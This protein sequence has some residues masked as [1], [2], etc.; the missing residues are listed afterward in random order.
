MV[1]SIAIIGMRLIAL[2]W[3]MSGLTITYFFGENWNDNSIPF[4]LSYVG[5]IIFGIILWVTA[6]YLQRY[7]IVEP[8]EGISSSNLELEE[9]VAAGSFLM[10]LYLFVTNIGNMSQSYFQMRQLNQP[11]SLVETFSAYGITVFLLSLILIF[12]NR[13]FIGRLFRLIR[14]ADSKVYKVE[15]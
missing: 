8:E 9:Y 7:F 12:G 10:G 2:Y 4:F 5:H 1:K 13:H 6:P 15:D 14:N 3:L 11:F